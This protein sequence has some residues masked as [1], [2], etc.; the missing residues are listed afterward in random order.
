MK[1]FHICNNFGAVYRNLF[2]NQIKNGDIVRAFYYTLNKK[3]ERIHL[4]K[5]FTAYW[6][7]SII[8]GPFLFHYRMK[9]VENKIMNYTPYDIE[10]YD[11]IHAHMLFSD[12]ELAHYLSKKTKVR[13]GVTVRNSDLNTWFYW[14]FF[15]NKKRGIKILEDA[16]FIIFHSMSYMNKL[17]EMVPVELRI[18]VLEKSFIIPNGVDEFWHNN[19]FYNRLRL[20]PVGKVIKILTVGRVEKNKNQVNVCKAIKLLRTQGYNIRY[21]V[22]GEITDNVVKQYLEDNDA[23]LTGQMEQNELIEI[24]RTSDIFVMPSFHETFGLAYVEALTQG[25]PVIYSENEGFDN[26]FPE[27]YI[28]YSVDPN[29]K[30]EIAGKIRRI[31]EE[32]DVISRNAL[33]STEKYKWELIAENTLEVYRK[34]KI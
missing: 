6:S 2:E 33:E 8:R 26:Q 29:N 16:E 3:K 21:I 23:E 34:E 1:V 7:K 11:I 19:I 24:Y 31:I 14:R 18:T 32:Y 9:K 25:L 17:L 22:V 28:G 5:Y 12:G 20:N 10:S 30:N 4:P 27:G 15:W 13:Y